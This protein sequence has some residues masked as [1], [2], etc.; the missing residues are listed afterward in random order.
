M[1]TYPPADF[2]FK[3]HFVSIYIFNQSLIRASLDVGED[4]E[5]TITWSRGR[6]IHP[7]P[8]TAC[9]GS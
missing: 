7:A 9:V 1:I 3:M 4:T 2:S 5:V 8:Y 6:T